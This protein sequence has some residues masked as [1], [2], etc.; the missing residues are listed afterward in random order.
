MYS[1]IDLETSGNKYQPE[2]IM[3][4]AIYRFDGEK[5]VDQ[6]LSLI[7]PEQS[8]DI[9]VKKLTGITNKMVKNAP[10]FKKLSKQIIKI[11]TETLLV[12]HNINYD[13]N[14]LKKNL[15][16]SGF[17]FQKKTIDTILL[18]KYFFPHEKKYS[19]NK[20]CKSLKIP[21][22]KNHRAYSDALA[23]LELFKLILQKDKN[24]KIINKL[25]K[26]H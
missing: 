4:I 10:K 3:E 23:T 15:L 11:T 12:G 19:L 8:I 14:I 7:N 16:N 13:Y 24:Q 26:N 1:I 2:A 20:L 6:L 9:F 21:L 18:A 22:M 5:I 25:S 17:L